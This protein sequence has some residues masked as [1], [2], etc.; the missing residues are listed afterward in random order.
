MLTSF[1]LFPIIYLYLGPADYLTEADRNCI[2][3]EKEVA[4]VSKHIRELDNLGLAMG[5]TRDRIDQFKAYSP[6]NSSLQV[7]KMMFEWRSREGQ[8]ATIEEF[9]NRLQEGGVDESVIREVF[10]KRN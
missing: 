8:K 5:F 9:V 10:G 6:H 3:G 1:I 7:L 2:L 4:L